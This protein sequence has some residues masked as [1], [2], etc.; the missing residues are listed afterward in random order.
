VP[1]RIP[2]PLR[3]AVRRRAARRCEYCQSAE[4]YC[5]YAFEVD[6]VVP[7]SAG[8]QTVLEN[9]ALACSTCN[10]HK[11][12]RLEVLDPETRQPTSLF[13]PRSH[14]WAEHFAWS[15]DGTRVIG[16]T[17]TGRASVEALQMNNSEVVSARSFWVTYGLHPPS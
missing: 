15:P 13:N 1:P 10:G 8:G 12:A 16:R 6:H 2:A 3:A 4:V 5:G 14:T 9:L 7:R 11:A 17:P